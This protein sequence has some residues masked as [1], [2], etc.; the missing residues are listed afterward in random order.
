M[1]RIVRF[2]GSGTTYNFKAY[3]SLL[4]GT[5]TGLWTNAPVVGD[6]TTW[7]KTISAETNSRSNGKWHHEGVRSVNHICMALTNGGGPVTEAVTAT[8]RLDRVCRSGDRQ[9]GHNFHMESNQTGPYVLDPDADDQT[10]Q[11]ATHVGANYVEPSGVPTSN[12]GAA[13]EGSNC[14]N[15]DYRGIRRK[16]RDP[17]LGDWSKAIAT[18]SAGHQPRIRCARLTYDF[19]FDDD[20]P[21]TATRQAEQAQARTVKDYLEAVESPTGQYELAI[22]DYGTLPGNIIQIAQNGVKAIDW[23]KA[24]GSAVS[25]EE[26]KKADD[27]N[28]D[29]DNDDHD[30]PPEQRVLDRGSEG[31]GQSDRA[32]A[33]AARRRQGPDQGDRRWRDGL[34]RERQR[35]GRQRDGDAADLESGAE[36]AGQDQR[37][38][39]QREDHGD[40]HPDRRHGGQQDEDAHAHAGSRHTEEKS[41][42]KRQEE[43]GRIG[44]TALV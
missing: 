26:V 29:D 24:A 39:V 28:H 10:R 16:A 43:I 25:K 33:R 1:R 34:E 21:V 44:L 20:A 2:D 17:T 42:Q 19:A 11:Q 37:P 40:V 3:L 18:G 38:Q 7:P 32:L 6:N 15:A 22:A 27:H 9:E 30:D 8:R 35:V 12:L 13:P 23:N 5:P 36:Q 31:Q 4:P 41:K 14:T